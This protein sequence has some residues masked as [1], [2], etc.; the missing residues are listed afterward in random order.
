MG[1]VIES[2]KKGIFYYGNYM[3][4]LAH[5]ED[6]YDESIILSYK[7]CNLCAFG[8][9]FQLKQLKKI[10]FYCFFF[11]KISVFV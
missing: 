3:T 4:F 2:N 1:L 6:N 10:F 5:I 11:Q 7:D 8:L 9:S